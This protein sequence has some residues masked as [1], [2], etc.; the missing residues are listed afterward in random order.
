M[1]VDDSI[2]KEREKIKNSVNEILIDY[3]NVSGLNIIFESIWMISNSEG[4]KNLIRNIGKLQDCFSDSN[5]YVL[6]APDSFI[7][8]VPQI[9]YSKEVLFPSKFYYLLPR[10]IKGAIGIDDYAALIEI[11]FIISTLNKKEITPSNV[12]GFSHRIMIL[13]DN[14]DKNID[15][16]YPN[17]DYFV[18][19]K[20]LKWNKEAKKLLNK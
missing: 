17:K 15:F 10:I 19:L 7:M 1:N 11:V 14:F 18:K 8:E 4:F 2:I 20:N 6:W 9:K 12:F 13:L 16:N 3:S 5:Y